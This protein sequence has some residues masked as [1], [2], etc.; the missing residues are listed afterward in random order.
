MG[1]KDAM[2]RLLNLDP[3]VKAIVSSGYSN[4]PV[5]ADYRSHGFKGVAVKPFGVR[6]FSRTLRA[7]LDGDA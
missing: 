4:D 5:M 6:A 1:G 7:V 3:A 2:S